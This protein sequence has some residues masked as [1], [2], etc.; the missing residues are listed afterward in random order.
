MASSSAS[1]GREARYVGYLRHSLQ[2]LAVDHGK[3]IAAG[4]DEEALEA[5]DAGAGER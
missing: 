5:G 2:L 4:V 1:S 3:A